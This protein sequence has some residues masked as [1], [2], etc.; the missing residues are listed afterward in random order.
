MNPLL[1]WIF[2]LPQRAVPPPRASVA[3]GGRGCCFGLMTMPSR[4]PSRVHQRVNDPPKYL[5]CVIYCLPFESFSRS[6]RA[7]LFFL[8]TCPQLF[9][10]CPTCWRALFI[11]RQQV[12]FR[13]GFAPFLLHCWF[14]MHVF[15]GALLSVTSSFSLLIQRLLQSHLTL[16]LHCRF[17]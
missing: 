9:Y 8:R 14:L 13:D 6:G 1:F 15:L 11:L 7:C 12:S 4:A 3:S 10:A 16:Y 17:F 2:D 5:Y